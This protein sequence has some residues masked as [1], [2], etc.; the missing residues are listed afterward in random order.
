MTTEVLTADDVIA[1][2]ALKPHPEGG[3]FRETFRD[4]PGHKGRSHSTA[5]LFLL[6]A[7]EVSRWHRV[8]AAEMFHWYGGAP[9]LLE[10]KQGEARHD[11]RLGPR[12]AQGRAPACGGP[13]RRLAVGAEPRRLDACRLHRG[14]RLRLRRIRDGPRRLRA[15][16]GSTNVMPPADMARIAQQK[17]RAGRYAPAH[18]FSCEPSREE[19]SSPC[20]VHS[21]RVS[22]AP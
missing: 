9:L 1:H 8:D 19:I 2:L 22:H 13:R 11:Y 6:K 3:W 4:E 12:L 18:C 17:L 5:I 20:G 15:V 7:G 21:C 14:A 10:V 16:R